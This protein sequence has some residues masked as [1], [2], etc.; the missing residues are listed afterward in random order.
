M[1]KVV[2]LSI[3]VFF[4]REAFSWEVLINSTPC[5]HM[6]TY[7][8]SAILSKGVKL[9]HI[10]V[11]DVKLSIL[12]LWYLWPLTNFIPPPD[13]ALVMNNTNSVC[14]KRVKKRKP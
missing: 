12:R 8:Y 1:K 9:L 11:L 13:A 5:N 14:S 10:F 4:L 6:Y 2:S 7:I 3:M